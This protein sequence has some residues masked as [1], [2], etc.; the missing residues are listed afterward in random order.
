M[1][2]PTTTP[3][4]EAAPGFLLQYTMTTKDEKGA[5]TQ[6]VS[7]ELT[8]LQVSST[9]LEMALF[10]APSAFKDMNVQQAAALKNPAFVE[11]VNRKKDS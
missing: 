3:A 7:Y 10:E 4:T 6:T 1:S 8:S 11:A 5:A 2:C 9:P